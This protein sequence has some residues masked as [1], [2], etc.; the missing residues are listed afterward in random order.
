MPAHYWK[1]ILLAA[2]AMLPLCLT[3]CGSKAKI[4]KVSTILPLDSTYDPTTELDVESDSIFAEATAA[5]AI[6]LEIEE[7][8]GELG[9]FFAKRLRGISAEDPTFIDSSFSAVGIDRNRFKVRFDG[10]QIAIGRWQTADSAPKY[11]DK[12]ALQTFAIKTLGGW[13]QA[14]KFSIEFK[15][16]QVA[17]QDDTITARLVAETFG[18][19]KPDSGL[20]ATS[21]WETK[22]KRSESQPISLSSIRVLGREELIV[23]VAEGQL[24]QD[25]TDSIFSKCDAWESQLKF[26]LDQWARQIPGLSVIGNQGVAVADINGDGLD[27]LYL[28]EGHGLANLMLL[29]NPDGT[30]RNIA[31]ESGVDILDETRAALIVDFDNDG[32]QDLALTTDENLV[33]YSNNG[34]EKFQLERKLRIGYDGSSLSAADF[35]LDGD[36]DLFVCKFNR[37]RDQTDFLFVPESYSASFSGGRNVLLRND[38]G[39]IFTD[40]TEEVGLTE[41]NRG[42]SR[43]GIWV[44]YDSDGD[45]D[46]YVTNEWSSSR[47]YENLNGWFNDV[48]E[49]KSMELTAQ[50]RSVSFGDFNND[51]SPDLFVANDVASRQYRVIKSSLDSKA[52][53]K[54]AG[55][56][57]IAQSQV[58]F[59]KDN[60]EQPFNAYPL[61]TPI[62]SS[63]SSFGSAVT[64]LNNDGLDDILVANGYLSRTTSEDLQ[65]F[66]ARCIAESLGTERTNSS[67]IRARSHKVGDLIRGGFSLSGNQRNRCYL[68]I[69]SVGFANFSAGSGIDL[70][71]DARSL[72]TSDW[73]NDGDTDVIMISRTGPRVRILCNQMQSKNQ[74]INI[75]LVGD[76]SNRDAIGA[77]VEVWIENRKAPI[78]RWVTAGSGYLAQ[79]S[80]N[81]QIGLGKEA[82]IRKV[83]V[84]WPGGSRQTFDR[85]K[86]NQFYTLTQNSAAAAEKTA[87]RIQLSIKAGSPRENQSLKTS[88]RSV[89]YPSSLLPPIRI[90]GPQRKWYRVESQ[91]NQA[92]LAV[93][94]DST[95]ASENVLQ[96]FAKNALE[97]E[98]NNIG[99]VAAFCDRRERATPMGDQHELSKQIIESSQWPY[100][101][102]VA[103]ATDIEKLKLACGEWFSNQQLP[104]L[105]FGVLLDRSGAVKAF[106]PA[107]ELGSKVLLKDKTLFGYGFEKQW[108]QLTG[109]SGFWLNTN[110]SVNLTRLKERLLELGLEQDVVVLNHRSAPST[111]MLLTTRAIELASLNDFELASEFFERALKVDPR[112]TLAHI[113]NG[114]LLRKL[115]ALQP[116]EAPERLE[117]LNTAVQSFQTAL[118]I[119]PD[120]AEAIIGF[121]DAST[122]QNLIDPAIEKLKEF[123]AAY[124]DSAR[125][126]AILGRLLFSK[127]QYIEATKHLT[128]AFDKHPTLPYVA[129]DLGFLYL[130]AGEASRAKKFLNLANRLQPSNRNMWR[131]L[132]EAEFATAQYAD[133]IRLYERYLKGSPKHLR[134]NC[135]LAWLLATCPFEPLRD[136]DRGIDL[137]MPMVKLYTASAF[138]REIAAACHAENQ[139]FDSAVQLQQEAVDMV[140]EKRSTDQYTD[141]QKTGLQNRL[142]LYRN[143]VAYRMDKLSEIPIR[144][145]GKRLKK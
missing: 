18:Q 140:R 89:F 141:D 119:E 66:W 97:L 72:A 62:F 126:N 118:S 108:D 111:A 109:R 86:A 57:L 143:Q 10:S 110:R 139:D 112:C 28:C 64:D 120:N 68:N 81:L 49:K 145:I 67:A 29:Q 123:V 84:I 91:P 79:S 93:F 55:K 83:D 22:W 12:G 16:Y 80:R 138:V 90:Q 51:A 7:R 103:A 142:E 106:Y 74:S 136:A 52:I 127:K 133:A 131:F 124:P 3:G 41:N 82:S 69:G 78:V 5:E 33:L 48:T 99:C 101:G 121:S 8:L 56:A 88:S 115:A 144:S 105:P 19:T 9:E 75:S 1:T 77:R 135:S 36:L 61:P 94:H 130:S 125:A 44:D 2:V 63:E 43:C 54:D 37:V 104:E 98:Q 122:D 107:S 134:S 15:I 76:S 128:I 14:N 47:L 95:P 6:E 17:E 53:S 73:D 30:V 85:L 96:D 116:A 13:K 21:L 50:A 24:L 102:G 71:N 100:P 87:K 58:W 42:H 70:L 25:F 65:S 32:D 23:T 39:W 40:V 114:Q 45:Q 35:D 117:I 11:S 137:I 92:L 34:S 59:S 129:G 26:G 31:A 38:E 4:E 20:Q 60:E 132:A 113:E 46:L 27:D